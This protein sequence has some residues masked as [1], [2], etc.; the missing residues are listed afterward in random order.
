MKHSPQVLVAPVQIR[1]SGRDQVYKD[2]VRF[3]LRDLNERP[4][5][6]VLTPPVP[7][8][9]ISGLRRWPT[10]SNVATQL[11]SLLPMIIIY[12]TLMAL[13]SDALDADRPNL[14]PVMAVVVCAAVKRISHIGLRAMLVLLRAESVYVVRM[15]LMIVCALFECL[16]SPFTYCIELGLT[17]SNVHFFLTYLLMQRCSSSNTLS[18]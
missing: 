9:T 7:L 15:A 2:V 13:V 16:I 5:A 17:V 4:H 6:P 10:P 8:P 12:G 11:S 1:T 18:I 3:L 14:L